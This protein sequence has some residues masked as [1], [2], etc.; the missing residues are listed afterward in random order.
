MSG[1]YRRLFALSGPSFVL[2]GFIARLPQTMSQIGTLLLVASVTGSFGIGGLCA[3][4]LAVANALGAPIG[5]ALSDRHGQRPVL[6]TQSV[7]AAVGMAALVMLSSQDVFWGWL[8]VAAAATG[9]LIPQVGTLARVRWRELSV[10]SG[11]DRGRLVETAFAYEGVADEIGFVLGPATVGVLAVFEPRLA[12]SVAAVT[13]LIFGVW[14]AL[15]P[16]AAL[17]GPAAQIPA[18][19]GRERLLTPALLFVV[20]GV[21]CMG[22][23]FGSIQTGTTALATAQGTPGLAGI[24]HGLLGVGSA[25]AGLM[26]PWLSPRWGHVLRWRVFT[27]GLV[28]LL[29]P[30]LVVGTLTQLVVLLIV[31]GFLVAPTLITLFTLTERVAPPAKLTTAMTLANAMI[32]LGYAA[33]AGVAGR[34]ADWGGHNPAYAVTVAAAALGVLLAVIGGLR[35]VHR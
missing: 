33:G 4:A 27:A 6:L 9:L 22:A 15:H 14:F 13:L 11:G 26:L 32:G 23:I 18:E 8:L 7:G 19:S 34:L 1:G 2:V 21:A 17:T 20:A 29:L 10:R 30:L 25:V 35:S 28:V 3:G 16:T 12:M 31:A 5:G 24:L